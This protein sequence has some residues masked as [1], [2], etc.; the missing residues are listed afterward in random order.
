VGSNPDGITVAGGKIWV[1]NSGGLNFPDYN[2]TLSVI[3]PV[4]L[5]EEK[6]VTAGVNPYV[7]APDSYG[8]LYLIARGN[9]GDIKS[10]LMIMDAGTGN[11]KHTFSEFEAI[12]FTLAGDTAYV[13]NYDWMSGSSSILMLDVKTETV[14]RNSFVTDGT[15]V[16]TVYGIAADPVSGLVYVSDAL[17]FAG[18]GK[19]YAFTS[20]GKLK[21]SFSAGMNPAVFAFLNKKVI[22][23]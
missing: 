9:Y 18:T 8:D 1:S 23:D 10:R 11:V 17:N 12:N 22:Q 15:V 3:D 19:V 6:Q 7:L 21:F 13:Y 2:N 16:Q 20:E 14:I 5:T 4:S